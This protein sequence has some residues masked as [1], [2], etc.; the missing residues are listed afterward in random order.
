MLGNKLGMYVDE[1]FR[2]IPNYNLLFIFNYNLLFSPLFS[3]AILRLFITRCHLRVEEKSEPKKIKTKSYTYFISSFIPKFTS[4]SPPSPPPYPHFSARQ[5]SPFSP[6]LLL[7]QFF[8][9][10]SRFFIRF[11][12][13][14]I[15]AP[16]SV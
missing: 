14:P 1:L 7:T 3:S 8:S 16:A 15:L 6:L 2:I 12:Y 10:F 5:T 13:K 4:L 9:R 11:Q